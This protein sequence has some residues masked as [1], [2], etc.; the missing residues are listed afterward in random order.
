VLLVFAISLSLYIICRSIRVLVLVTNCIYCVLSAFSDNRLV[1]SHLFIS[2]E[3]P[4]PY[5]EI[6]HNIGSA[7]LFN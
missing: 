7:V 4:K 5:H 2:Y 6:I 3:I 1:A